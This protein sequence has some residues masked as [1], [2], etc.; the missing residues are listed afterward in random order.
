MCLPSL[1]RVVLSAAASADLR[2]SYVAVLAVLFAKVNHQLAC[3]AASPASEEP[4]AWVHRS[5]AG[6]E[7]GKRPPAVEECAEAVAQRAEAARRH[8]SESVAPP[9]DGVCVR[10]HVRANR[11]W[12]I[13]SSQF[14]RRSTWA[15]AS[16]L[17]GCVTSASDLPVAAIHRHEMCW[18]LEV[19]AARLPDPGSPGP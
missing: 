8:R 6:V 12:P 11:S 1:R 18:V 7:R 16:W 15:P 14:A 2:L 9:R 10:E 19:G 13:S 3:M 5:W 17:R 4:S